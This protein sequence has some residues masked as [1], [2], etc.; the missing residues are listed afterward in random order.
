AQAAA[1]DTATYRRE[2]FDYPGQG[3][4]DPFR[5]LQSFASTGPRLDQLQLSGI[6]YGGPEGES[7]V[8]LVDPSTNARYRLRVG[9]SVGFARLARVEPRR[10]VF[11]VR[12]F[13]RDRNVVLRLKQDEESS[14]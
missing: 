11:A 6:L 3:R 12:G 1:A 4:R 13:G 14:R 5:P 2:I 7:V 8:V 10:A 9:D